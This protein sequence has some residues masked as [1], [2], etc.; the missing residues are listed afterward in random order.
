M[1]TQCWK[2]KTSSSPSVRRLQL[3]ELAQRSTSTFS[4][5]PRCRV[6]IFKCFPL[7]LF[8]LLLHSN[9][10]ADFR[11]VPVAKSTNRRPVAFWQSGLRW[12]LIYTTAKRYGSLFFCTLRFAYSQFAVHSSSSYPL[13]LFF[14]NLSFAFCIHLHSE[15]LR[16]E[17]NV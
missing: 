3:L 10:D 11:C 4:S 16:L 14:A 17:C 2:L 1:R 15:L 13:F 12:L 5:P 9:V 8:P 7:A 6:F